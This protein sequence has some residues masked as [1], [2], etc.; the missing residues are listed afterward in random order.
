MHHDDQLTQEPEIYRGCPAMT[1]AEAF[2]RANGTDDAEE[3]QVTINAVLT[4]GM[5]IAD[6]GIAPLL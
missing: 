3:R 6:Q 2:L 4:A 1:L 5:Y